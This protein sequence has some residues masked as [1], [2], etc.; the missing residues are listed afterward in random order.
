M[1]KY[2]KKEIKILVACVASFIVLLSISIYMYENWYNESIG[3]DKV[4]QLTEEMK[5]ETERVYGEPK[6]TISHEDKNAIEKIFMKK[7][8]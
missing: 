4:I 6:V 5:R 8:K 2:T 1:K 3:D 7:L